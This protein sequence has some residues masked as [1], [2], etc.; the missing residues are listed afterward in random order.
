MVL[1]VGIARCLRSRGSTAMN[2]PASLPRPSVLRRCFHGDSGLRAEWRLL[3]FFVLFIAALVVMQ[4]VGSILLPTLRSQRDSFL[5]YIV[6]PALGFVA[7]LLA[8][9]VMAESEARNFSDYGLPWRRMFRSEFWL[10]VAVGFASLSLLLLVMWAFG[11]FG[12]ES[13]ALRGGE[14]W[15]YGGSYALVFIVVGLA[16][17]C[18]SFSYA[19]FTLST[20]IGFWPAA[21][22]SSAFFGLVHLGNPGETWLG[23]MNAGLS[24]MLSCLLLRRTGN[25]WMAIGNHAAWDW[26]ETYLYGVANSGHV[27]E[28]HFFSSSISGPVWLS[29]GSVGPEGSVL[30]TGLLVTLWVVV[31]LAFPQAK[32]PLV[33]NSLEPVGTAAGQGGQGR[34]SCLGCEPAGVSDGR[35]SGD[36]HG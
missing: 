14:V 22:L 29:G 13:I 16:E 5:S 28:G 1:R 25:L 26:A 11:V 18:I 33:R 20:G 10:G 19:L 23:V 32:F 3:A 8:I 4:I 36:G 35:E 9:S 31:C 24:G 6:P 27:T 2:E 7:L 12:L 21:I 17:D 15:A 30:C 34:E